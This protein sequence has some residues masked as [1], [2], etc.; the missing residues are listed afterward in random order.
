MIAES[1]VTGVIPN[2]RY[3]PVIFLIDIQQYRVITLGN[4]SYQ[5]IAELLSASLD[6][7]GKASLGYFANSTTSSQLS[8]RLRPEE[9]HA[10]QNSS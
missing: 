1:K 5:V 9:T 8:P 6:L 10:T 2:Q 4:L 7:F 3:R